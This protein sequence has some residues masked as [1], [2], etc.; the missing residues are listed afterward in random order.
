MCTCVV[1]MEALAQV[2]VVQSG[3]ADTPAQR[4]G[5]QGSLTLADE[6]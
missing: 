4:E 6:R 1:S 2:V 3:E 5:G